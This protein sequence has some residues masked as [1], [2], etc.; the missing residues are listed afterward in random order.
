VSRLLAWQPAEK[1]RL[2]WKYPERSPAVIAREIRN[3]K[4]RVPFD[5]FA[6]G[7]SASDDGGVPEAGSGESE[8]VVAKV[9]HIGET[10]C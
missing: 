5:A 8:R 3:R 4:R 10:A 2:A 9:G 6:L 1:W 7:T